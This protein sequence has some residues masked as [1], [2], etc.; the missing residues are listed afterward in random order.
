MSKIT[1][2]VNKSIFC[3][4]STKNKPIPPGEGLHNGDNKHKILNI[5][6]D[7]HDMMF[8]DFLHSKYSMHD[9]SD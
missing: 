3:Y 9:L 5:F 2:T 7:I 6:A 1:I 8:V 4:S